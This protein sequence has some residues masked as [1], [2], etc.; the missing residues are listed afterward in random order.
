MKQNIFLQYKEKIFYFFKKIKEKP[1]NKLYIVL[2]VLI[3]LSGTYFYMM[4]GRYI[5]TDN[6]YV[7]TD[8]I[9]ISSDLS[10]RVQRVFVK[11]NQQV[12][13]GD[14]LFQLEDTPFRLLVQKL[15]AQ[16]KEV[17]NDIEAKR[18]TFH[19]KEASIKQAQKDVLFYKSEFGRQT[20]LAS[21][22]NTTETKREESQNNFEKSEQQLRQLKYDLDNA[23]AALSGKADIKIEEHPNYLE[24]K[25]DYEKA[26]L[27]LKKTSV[28]AP[29]NGII[30]QMTL[31]A[32]DYV[33]VGSPVF[34]L[35]LTDNMWVEANLKETELELV[36]PGQMARV[37][38][39]AYSNAEWQAIVEGISPASGSEFSVLPPQNATGNW[40]KIVQRIPVRLRLKPLENA[41][42]LRA[43]L[44]ASVEIDTQSLVAINEKITHS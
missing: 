21:K 18:A 29:S 37:S 22:K 25:A 39:D 19:A 33:T 26:C 28:Y 38:V 13:A 31:V 24:I 35:V 12:K 27:E 8:K 17:N 16:L 6:A 23:L 41:P 7:K 1:F 34:S 42:I 43:G 32:G 11:D 3:P 20:I 4:N 2:P 15:E 14:I 5:S 10:Y 44:S 36:K 30:T 9:A 40:V